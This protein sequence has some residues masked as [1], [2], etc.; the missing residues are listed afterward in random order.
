MGSTRLP[1]LLMKKSVGANATLSIGE[2]KEDKLGRE[3][4]YGL[5][6]PVK[7]YKHTMLARPISRSDM[8]S[9][10]PR[11]GSSNDQGEGSSTGAGA[12]RSSQPE[13]RAMRMSAFYDLIEANRAGQDNLEKIKP[14][15]AETVMERGY[16]LGADVVPLPV[17]EKAEAKNNTASLQIINFGRWKD[18]SRALMRAPSSLLTIITPSSDENGKWARCRTSLPIPRREGRKRR[19]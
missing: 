2:A 4:P 1:Q 7:V 17:D 10:L 16:K 9:I 13:G 12:S 6:I 5:E 15:P 19:S 14:L 18:V 11:A 3:V 8:A